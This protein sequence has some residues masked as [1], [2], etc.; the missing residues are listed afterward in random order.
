M[1]VISLSRGY[2]KEANCWLMR[3]PLPTQGL[4]GTG[5]GTPTVFSPA[6]DLT[7]PTFLPAAVVT[8]TLSSG[9]GSGSGIGGGSLGLGGGSGYSFTTSGG[10]SLGAGLGGSGFSATSNRVLGGSGSSVKFVSTT[11]SSRKSYKH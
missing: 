11:S 6:L 1:A 7:T 10:H 8:S 3:P 4:Q 9:Y 2:C 5:P